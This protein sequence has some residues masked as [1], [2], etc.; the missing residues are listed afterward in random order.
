MGYIYLNLYIQELAV[1]FIGLPSYPQGMG[2]N[3]VYFLV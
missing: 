3:E 1:K 2:L